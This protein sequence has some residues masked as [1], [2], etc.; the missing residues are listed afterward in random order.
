MFQQYY[1]G[2]EVLDLPIVAMGLF[3]AIFVLMILRTL[4]YRTRADFDPVAALPLADEQHSHAAPP[5]RGDRT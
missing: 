5:A 2:L 3:M 1:R 4:F